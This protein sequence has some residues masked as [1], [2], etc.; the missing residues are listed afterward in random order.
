MVDK[1][2]VKDFVAEKIGDEYVVKTLGLWDDFD[3]IDFNKLPQKFVIKCT[4]NSG[5]VVV[6]SDK[7]QLNLEKTKKNIN[8]LLKRNYFYHGREWPYKNVKPRIILHNHL[9]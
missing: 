7:S 5:G 8:K 2:L 9:R 6:C 4:H 3:E 1:I